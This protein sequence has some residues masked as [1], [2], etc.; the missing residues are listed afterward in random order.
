MSKYH[1][2]ADQ[3]LTGTD[4]VQAEWKKTAWGNLEANVDFLSRTHLA[5][6]LNVLEIGCGKGAM[7]SQLRLQGYTVTGID[8]DAEA[9][10]D[11]R[12]RQ[13]DIPVELASGDAIPFPDSSFDVVLSFDVFE[14]IKDSNR[15]LAEVRRVLK[16]GSY[17]MFQTPNKWTNIP[18]EI[19]RHWKK[20]G[21]G[22]LEGYRSLT[23]DHCA[24]HNYWQL[25]RRF[26][27][28]G[29]DTQ[30]VDVPVVNDYFKWKMRTYF[31]AMGPFLTTVLSPDHLPRPLRTNFYAVAHLR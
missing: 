11:S 24:L 9:L 6:P 5:P 22:P 4:L 25:R 7:L 27:L 19:L 12:A 26:S 1:G 21:M 31:G 16:T 8:V 20:Y 13:P 15:H 29:F 18:F 28:N 3:A 10:A 23:E 17:Y 2:L 30:F 14:H